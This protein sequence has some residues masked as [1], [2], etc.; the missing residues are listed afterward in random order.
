MVLFPVNEEMVMVCEICGRRPAYNLYPRG[1]VLCDEH[2]AGFVESEVKTTIDNYSMF[3]HHDR[4]MVAV[5]GGKDSVVL[6]KVLK[7]LGY[8]VIAF[9][10]DLGVEEISERSK[11]VFFG[12]VEREKVP[13]K[14]LDL[15]DF[16]NCGIKE[17]S[18]IV[19]RPTCSICGTIRRYLMDRYSDSSVV[20]TGHNLDD[21]VAFLFLNLLNWSLEYIV[22][23]SPVLREEHGF[24]RKV[25]PLSF[26]Y[27][28][29]TKLY[30]SINGLEHVV[31]ECPFSK[32]ATT[33]LI[34][35]SLNEIE[36]SNPDFKLRFLRSFMKIK[37]KIGGSSDSRVS[38]Q[39]CVKCGYPTTSG[40]C[41]FCRF[42]E[43]ALSY[44]IS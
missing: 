18:K 5:S 1:K 40:I 28:Y 26:V 23:Q 3:T 43:K 17:L 6:L 27:E 20:A 21:E 7:N 35:K 25:K 38:L 2:F 14:I 22:R 13:Y 32:G 8:K 29:E 10:I 11:E 31:G 33:L 41:L 42:R 30:A 9:H 24:S 12:V 4:V 44:S 19:K 15:R 36:K 39:P 16:F 34:K 37:E